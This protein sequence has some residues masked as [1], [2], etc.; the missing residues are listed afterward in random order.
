MTAD[1]TSLKGVRQT[2]ISGEQAKASR[3]TG[4][5]FANIPIRAFV[6]L[7]ASHDNFSSSTSGDNSFSAMYLKYDTDRWYA[8]GIYSYDNGG[9]HARV[10]AYSLNAGAEPTTALDTVITGT[11]H[12]TDGDWV[13]L[14]IDID[15]D[16]NIILSVQ[17]EDTGANPNRNMVPVF[18]GT[19]T[20]DTVNKF[21]TEVGL[22]SNADLFSNSTNT[23][24]IDWVEIYTSDTNAKAKFGSVV[25]YEFN[26]VADFL[27]FAGSG[28]ELITLTGNRTVYET[29]TPSASDEEFNL[30]P[31][32]IATWNLKPPYQFIFNTKYDYPTL[33]GFQ[34][35]AIK[36]ATSGNNWLLWGHR[37]ES[38]DGLY[39]NLSTI[40]TSP[41]G[42]AYDGTSRDGVWIWTKIDFTTDKEIII[43]DYISDDDD[44]PEIG[45]WVSGTAILHSGSISDVL[46]EIH[47][48]H[49][50]IDATGNMVTMW[51]YFTV[52]KL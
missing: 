7:R 37:G 18:S 4:T 21:I 9:S 38:A 42:G 3:T 35:I 24:E 5:N 14:Q 13:V 27:N 49:D 6:R 1:L 29:T 51:D 2:M 12:W 34:R 11:D 25:E 41:S 40:N 15:R 22:I 43:Y 17:N 19:M 52:R 10:L 31:A 20:G 28:N 32:V 16:K 8:F 30:D 50:R 23:T 26:V 48:E 47:F 33:A 44:E 46:E 36:F 39:A 45:E